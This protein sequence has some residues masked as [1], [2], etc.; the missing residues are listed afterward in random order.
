ME[1]AERRRGVELTEDAN[2]RGIR[3]GEFADQIVA[4]EPRP[5]PAEMKRTATG[6]DRA[7]AD[8]AAARPGGR[9]KREGRRLA[10]RTPRRRRAELGRNSGR[11]GAPNWSPN[12]ESGGGGGGGA[13][14]R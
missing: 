13:G 5:N 4:H 1:K 11:S 6:V 9:S 2:F 8:K 3:A 14:E 10:E 7:D 12:W